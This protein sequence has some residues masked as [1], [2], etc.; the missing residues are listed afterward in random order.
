MSERREGR[1]D[2][3]M[4]GGWAQRWVRG[5]VGRLVGD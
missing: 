5:Q 1:A 4:V 2:G 3:S